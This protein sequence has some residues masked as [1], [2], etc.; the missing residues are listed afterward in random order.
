MENLMRNLGAAVVAAS[1]L[2]T[3]AFAGTALPAGKPAGV[4]KAQLDDHNTILIIAGVGLAAL[5]IA[6]A[7][8]TGGGPTSSTTCISTA[9]GSAVLDVDH[10]A[11]GKTSSIKRIKQG[12]PLL[13]LFRMCRI[14]QAAEA[15]QS[16]SF[17]RWD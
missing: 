3:N 6:L 12:E 15:Y 5:G 4:Q 8:S 17:R 9:C 7:M 1:L 11:L 14:N 10:D 2:V 16:R 13:S